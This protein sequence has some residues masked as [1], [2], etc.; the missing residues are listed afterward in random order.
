MGGRKWTEEEIAILKKYGSRK[1]IDSIQVLLDRTFSAI[2]S[3][4][5]RLGIKLF[6]YCKDC[7]IPIHIRACRCKSCACKAVWA[8]EELRNQK[9]KSHKKLWANEENRAR[10]SRERNANKEWGYRQSEAV[11]AA[12]ERGAYNSEETRR[13]HAEA[14]QAAWD[15]GD[16]NSEE[17]SRKISEGIKAA[18]ARGAYD[19]VFQSPTSIELQV[20]AALDIVGIE[21]APQY[22]PDGYTRVYDE[23]IPPDTLMEINGDYFHSEEHF[24]GIQKRDAEKAQWAKEHGYE[25]IVIW[26]HEIRDCGAW[27]MIMQ[28]GLLQ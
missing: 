4:A 6:R 16:F 5:H 25:L 18:R 23:F 22:R 19:G 1:E 14:I 15:R 28:K 27:A 2:A 8:T 24:P 17:R 9:I 21:H 7:G 3:K 11:K 20:A 10:R 26:E 13:K 12:W